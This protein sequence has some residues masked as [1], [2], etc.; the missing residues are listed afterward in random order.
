MAVMLT[1]EVLLK[2][3]HSGFT[4]ELSLFPP[5]PDRSAAPVHRPSCRGVPRVLIVE[6]DRV[7]EARSAF[8]FSKH[9][10][11]VSITAMAP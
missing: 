1:P 6:K 11:G 2:K 3:R 4:I 7:A 8:F 5:P 9:F 10:A